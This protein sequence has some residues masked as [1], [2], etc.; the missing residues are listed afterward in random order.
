VTRTAPTLVPLAL[1]ACF[2]CLAPSVQAQLIDD[3]EVRREGADAVVRM[4]FTT[5]VRYLRSVSTRNGELTQAYYELLDVQGVHAPLVPGERRVAGGGGL[6][7][8]TVTDEALGASDTERKLV[9]RLAPPARMRVRAGRDNRSIEAV[10]IGL[11][12]QVKPAAPV[13]KLPVA[14]AGQRFVVVLHSSPDPSLQL[15]APVPAALQDYALGTAQRVVDGVTLY[16][17]NLG[18]FANRV[19]AERA[20]ELLRKRFPRARLLALQEPPAADAAGMPA[21][22]VP[23]PAVDADQAG[24]A[25]LATARAA[26][27]RGDASAAI[28]A[29]NRLLDLPPN[30]ASREAQ[31]LIGLL[32]MNAGDTARARREFELF[33]KLYPSGADSRRVA[34]QLARL[35]A[36]PVAAPEAVAEVA[37]ST[38]TINGSAGLYYYGG[39][40]KIRSEEFKDSGLGGLP[41]LVQNPTLTATDQRLAVG[42]V[43]LNY[44]HRSAEQDLRFVFRDT[45]QANL[46]PGKGS[47]N[48]LS[49]LYVDHRSLRNGTSI[50][51]G[52]QSP[53]G[54]GVL[55]RFDGALAGYSF[56]PKWKVN[57]VG[58]VPADKLQKTRRHFYG[59]SIDADALTDRV[60]ASVY[61]IE[62]KLDGV[63][64][65]R[66][67]GTDV[68]YF[69]GGTFVSGSLD[70]DVVLRKVNIAALQ[71]TWQQIDAA[72]NA[73]TTVNYSIDRRAQ[74]MVMLGNALFFQDPKC[75]TPG[76]IPLRLSDLSACSLDELRDNVRATTAFANQALLGVT[77][78]VSEHWQVGGD[79]R[80]ANI[81]EIKPVPDILPNGQPATGNIWGAGGQ[82]IG[83][84]LYSVRDT[85]VFNLSYQTAPTFKGLLLM[86]NNLSALDEFWQL[87]PSMQVYRQTSSNG[88][89]L[90]RWKPGM[91]VTWRVAQSWVLESALDYEITRISSPT[92]NENSNRAFYYLGGRYDF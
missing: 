66:A 68:R 52:R 51:L 31:E 60:G 9:I 63:T 77:T 91:R 61:A 17:F 11:G 21:A 90:L 53:L 3:V 62:H 48:R 32:R 26:E 36:A 75:S 12:A 5:P 19:E 86:Y 81:G 65:R 24:T 7:Q 72:G 54:G 71:G 88:A 29:L 78:P 28:E 56:A 45:Y 18:P 74:P 69:N 14:Q 73:G 22:P 55:G 67:I 44:R 20:L 46:L 70:Y 41:E 4:R 40:S 43:D 79:L 64:D 59:T 34:A 37:P 35:P 33:L 2:A 38:T 13:G 27:A 89:D 85:H 84:N 16:E 39:Q 23:A 42:S 8:L 76:A 92:G 58:G 30:R 83:S 49:A 10:L 87:E 25:L 82:L 57:L 15:P 80:L 50:R 47:R 6:P 1:A